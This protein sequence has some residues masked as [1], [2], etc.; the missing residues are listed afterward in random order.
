MCMQFTTSSTCSVG[1]WRLA[2][3][4]KR[5]D[6]QTAVSFSLEDPIYVLFNPWNAGENCCTSLLKFY[7]GMRQFQGRK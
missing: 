7:D 5:R 4:T 3:D 6:D 2:I 1:K